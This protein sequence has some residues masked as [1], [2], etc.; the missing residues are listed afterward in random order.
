MKLK[1]KMGEKM[2]L[3]NFADKAIFHVEQFSG[4][5]DTISKIGR[6]RAALLPTVNPA[7]I[8]GGYNYA[9]KGSDRLA[10]QQIK[11]QDAKDIFQLMANRLAVRQD[12]LADRTLEIF[13]VSQTER[14]K[15]VIPD[16]QAMAIQAQH[17]QAMAQAEGR[18]EQTGG[19]TSTRAISNGGVFGGSA[20][21]TPF[22]RDQNEKLGVG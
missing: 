22:G 8:D 17:A 14:K 13:E 2:G 15:A 7:N 12:W 1:I 19:A 4:P 16:E 11:R 10:N 5:D 21:N 9:F 18:T 20:G 3:G 6:E